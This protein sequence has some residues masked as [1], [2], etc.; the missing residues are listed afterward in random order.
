MITVARCVRCACS[1]HHRRSNVYT[2]LHFRFFSFFIFY[3]VCPLV[4]NSKMAL[5]FFWQTREKF[6]RTHICFSSVHFLRRLAFSL[7]SFLCS[8]GVFTLSFSFAF[9]LLSSISVSWSTL[10]TLMLLRSCVAKSARICKSTDALVVRL[11]F[12]VDLRTPAAHAYLI[13]K[14]DAIYRSHSHPSAKF[15]FPPP[16]IVSILL[17]TKLLSFRS[18]SPRRALFA[19]EHGRT[20][21]R[22]KNAKSAQSHRNGENGVAVQTNNP[23]V[24]G[25]LLASDKR[26]CVKGSWRRITYGNRPPKPAKR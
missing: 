21:H 13:D 1:R 9:T 8:L 15:F 16:R 22:K 14:Y 18:D 25:S 7:R 20:R 10:P 19:R 26:V 2:N 3:S 6:A 12:A 23:N 24:F 17:H 5:H 11:D 4:F